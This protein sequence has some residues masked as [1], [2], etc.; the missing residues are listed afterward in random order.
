MGGRREGGAEGGEKVTT[1]RGGGGGSLC[2]GEAS[3][4]AEVRRRSAQ[5]KEGGKEERRRF[6]A[7]H[8]RRPSVS[9]LAAVSGYL[10][11]IPQTESSGCT[12]YYSRRLCYDRSPGV[13]VEGRRRKRKGWRVRRSRR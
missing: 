6:L 13:L 5:R 9:M 10:A 11:H 7:D 1:G 12:C 4:G 3:F 2:R 8:P